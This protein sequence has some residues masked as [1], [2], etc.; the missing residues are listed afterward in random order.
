MFIITHHRNIAKKAKPIVANVWEFAAAFC[1][2]LMCRTIEL[3]TGITKWP[4]LHQ[5]I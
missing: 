1:K 5:A 4:R 2:Q 3:V